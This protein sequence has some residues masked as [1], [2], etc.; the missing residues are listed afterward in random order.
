MTQLWVD[1]ETTGINEYKDSI[2]QLAVMVVVDNEIKEER[3]W[4]LKPYRPKGMDPE[5]AAATGLT[6]EI[7]D[8]FPD[9]SIAFREF[10]E[11]LDKY[12]IGKKDRAYFCGYN[13]NFDLQFVKEW[14]QENGYFDLFRKVYTPCIDVMYWAAV[15]FI[16]KGIRA[17][18]KNFKLGTVYET[19]FNEPLESAH[20]A[21]ADIKG[22]YRIYN[23]LVDKYFPETR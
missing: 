10:R 22:T 9:Q 1:T 8:A 19:L 16:L 12:E 3:N 17:Q 21:M 7:V 2:V 14:F 23:V 6:Q 11:L 20:N 5:A 18:M 13:V 4:N 15:P